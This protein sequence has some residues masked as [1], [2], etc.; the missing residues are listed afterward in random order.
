[1]SVVSLMAPVLAISV[2]PDM[3]RF[4][5]AFLKPMK[6]KSCVR[7]EAKCVKKMRSSQTKTKVSINNVC[8]EF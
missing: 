6:E 5:E 8:L 7:D 4:G 1:M 2:T 3:I